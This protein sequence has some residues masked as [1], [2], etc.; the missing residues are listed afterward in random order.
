MSKMGQDVI[1]REQDG[2]LVY[3]EGRGYVDADLY[4]CEYMK[5]EQFEKEFDEAFG[6]DDDQGYDEY[7]ERRAGLWK[8]MDKT[9]EDFF[10]YLDKTIKKNEEK[11]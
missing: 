4:A 2:E 9:K 8:E 6:K 1:Q 7:K 5:T 10:D 3:V 11:K